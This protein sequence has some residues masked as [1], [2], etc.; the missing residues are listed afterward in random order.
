MGGT[1]GC[2]GNLAQSFGPHDAILRSRELLVRRKTCWLLSLGL[3]SFTYSIE[4]G[5]LSLFS[6][7]SSTLDIRPQQLNSFETS[8]CGSVALQ[9]WKTGFILITS[10][11]FDLS[12]QQ[13]KFVWD[14]RLWHVWVR[15]QL[16]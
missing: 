9:P 1:S 6:I 15:W 13:L 4:F 10:R 11:A 16:S 3:N 8:G 5:K 7:Q 2:A 14:Q 12:P